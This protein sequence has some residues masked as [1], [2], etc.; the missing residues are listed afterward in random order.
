LPNSR[1][2]FSFKE[3]IDAGGCDNYADA[4][5]KMQQTNYKIAVY[6]SAILSACERLRNQERP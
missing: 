1:A 6:S 2:P 4:E 3:F 5:L